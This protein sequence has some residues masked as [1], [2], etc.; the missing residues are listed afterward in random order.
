MKSQLILVKRA[1]LLL[2]LSIVNYQPSTQAQGTAFTYQ[3]RLNDGANPASGTFDLKFSLFTASSGGSVAAGPVTN[4]AATVSNGLFATA[5]DFGPG[6]FNGTTYWLEIAVRTNGGGTFATL[7]PRQQLTPTPYAIFA[8][9][10]SAAGLSG[11]IPAASIGGTYGNPVNF[12]NGADSFNGTFYGQFFGSSFVGG[13]FVGSFIGSGVG[14]GD[15]WHTTGNLNTSPTNNNFLGTLDNQPLVIKVNGQQAH[16]YEPAYDTPN[17]IGGNS[18][19]SV[20]PGLSGV[21]IGGGGSTVF[22]NQPNLVTN[23]GQYAT[24]AGGYRNT[25]TN[26]G[27]AILGGS[28]NFAGG[29]FA[30]M[31]GGQFNTALG[32]YSV[33]GGGYFNTVRA[34]NY[35]AVIGG[36]DHNLIGNAWAVIAGGYYNTNNGLVGFIGAG[37]YNIIGSGGYYA[38]VGGG[39]YNFANGYASFIGA[40]GANSINSDYS[41]IGG[42]YQNVILTND[43]YSVIGGGWLNNIQNNADQSVIAG[44]NANSIQ[45]AAR[46]SFV[47]GGFNN[48]IQSNAVISTIVGGANNSVGVGSYSST[49]GGGQNNLIHSNA[50]HSVIGG[51]GFNTIG[52]NANG[53]AIDSGYLNTIGTSADRAT[54]AGGN[55][56]VIQDNSTGSTIGGGIGNAVGTNSGVSTIAGGNYNIIQN[57]AAGPAIGGGLFNTNGGYAA[58]V[59]GGVNNLASGAYSF[60]AGYRAKA[61]HDGSFVWADSQSADFG[62]TTVNQFNVRANGGVRF[63]TA[64][65]GITL[66]GQPILGSSSFAPANGSANYIQNQTAVAQSASF[67]INGSMTATSLA[68]ANGNVSGTASVNSLSLTNTL[69][70]PGAGIGT[71]TP[72]FVHRATAANIETGATHRTTINNPLCDGDPNA[73]LI[74]TH[75]YSPSGILDINPSSVYYNGALSK[76]QIYHDNFVAM[77]T[78]NTY[79]VLIVKP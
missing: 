64:G 5:I 52:T 47:G 77:T 20:Q 12:N 30:T 28:G 7:T 75:N 15:V 16:R 62:S 27:G 43:S 53:A 50:D 38:F 45:F 2:L 29:N 54:I 66:D 56:N 23:N 51:G 76:W 17:V 42:G 31:G 3:G 46:E 48:V 34:N 49:I 14:L 39:F 71:A 55:G 11:T 18:I 6:I 8:E 59:P 21:T 36:G 73:I 22:G 24:I 1:V 40:G 13:N 78:N 25:V 69:R 35:T 26:Y 9:G 33:I 61:N 68:V 65:A 60:A 4:S 32:D 67:N 37:D 10:A 79:N 57:N 19:N 44:G 63:V 72:V 58:T 41:F 74:I 70:V